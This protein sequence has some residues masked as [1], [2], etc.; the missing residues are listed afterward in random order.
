MKALLFIATSLLVTGAM[1]TDHAT[2][3]PKDA[4]HAGMHQTKEAGK[5]AMV[6]SAKKVKEITKEEAT[7]LCET[8]K[9]MD[10]AK[11]VVEKMTPAMKK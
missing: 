3:A 2:T 8:E 10:I 7:K 9:A 4:A 11:C 5:K 6:A 1:A